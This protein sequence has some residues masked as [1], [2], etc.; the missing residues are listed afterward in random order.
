MA[1]S[2]TRQQQ[3]PGKLPVNATLSLMVVLAS[4]SLAGCSSASHSTAHQDTPPVST[5]D[6]QATTQSERRLTP[7]TVTPDVRVAVVDMSFNPSQIDNNFR[8]A[9]GVDIHSGTSDVRGRNEWHGNTIASVITSS[10]HGNPVVDLI[11]VE[12]GSGAAVS[13]ELDYAI[14]AAAQRGARVI[15]ASFSGRLESR[16]RERRMHGLS[17]AESYRRV[18]QANDGKGAVYTVPAGNDGRPIEVGNDALYD[19]QPGLYDMMLIAVGTDWYGN[20]HA[21]SNFPGNDQK[22]VARTLGAPFDNPR[23]PGR[24]TSFTSAVLA[25]HAAT[26]IDRWPHL[27]A[28]DIS[29]RLLDTARKDS[30][31]FNQNHCG[32][33]GSTNCGAYYLGQG[34]VDI[35]AAMAPSGELRLPLREETV[36]EGKPVKN[37]ALQ[38]GSAFG[39]AGARQGGTDLRAFDRLGRDYVIAVSDLI[40]SGRAR[41]TRISQHLTRLMNA[42]DTSRDA[43]VQHQGYR[44]QARLD[45]SGALLESRLSAELGQAD[46]GVFRLAGDRPGLDAGITRAD[47]MEML[48]FQ[49]SAGIGDSLD[50][51]TGV[52]SQYA[53]DEHLTLTASHWRAGLAGSSDPTLESLGLDSNNATGEPSGYRAT[54]SDLGLDVTLLPTAASELTLSATLG[55][56]DERQGLLGSHGRG[57]LS[58]DGESRTRFA[59]LS[60]SGKV[61]DTLSGFAEVEYGSGSARG[62]GLL[63][64]LD[65]VNSQRMAMGVQWQGEGEQA[66][67]TLRR[68]LQ[69]SQATAT[70]DVPVG[71]QA[72]GRVVRQRHVQ[73][74]SPS[75]RQLDLEF[76][77]R[78]M[79]G[80]H[81]QWGL[82]ALLTLD[83][84]HDAS[85]GHDA[86]T[87]LHYRHLW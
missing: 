38:L 62:Q 7:R 86:A 85:A 75:G 60:L 8:V 43:R 27:D 19:H 63:T 2:R 65:D 59:G 24:G 83:P 10:E 50:Q 57:A 41:A 64:R 37:T 34:V 51:I 9:G 82:N 5:S 67:F 56:L 45:D 47:M 17:S 71:R 42:F 40:G 84:Q 46:I 13:Y 23:G 22:L 39:G 21:N 29:R 55:Q 26:L 54:R 48:S 35:E 11:K 74:L 80:E 87:M 16:D 31:L 25:S 78:A 32:E 76:G 3:H 69:V 68:P 14:G 52:Q 61:S 49:G 73:S 4:L 20:R 1:P 33:D 79:L 18:T 53:L 66:A 15:N 44:F 36:A 28:A 58:L 77:Y 70:F 12:N 6:N 30:M 72:N 81:G